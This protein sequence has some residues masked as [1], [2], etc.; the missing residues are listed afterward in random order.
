MTR[1]DF[2]LIAKTIAGPNFLE[3]NKTYIARV[4]ASS[5]A[6]TNPRFNAERFV[7]AATKVL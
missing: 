4:F 6:D 5:L 1:K 2:E 7:A 3:E